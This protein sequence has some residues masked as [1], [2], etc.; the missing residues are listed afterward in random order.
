[1]PAT[2]TERTDP[3]AAL[4]TLTLDRHLPFQPGQFVTLTRKPEGDRHTRRAYSIA[5]APGEPLHFLFVEV[6][7]GTVSTGLRDLDPGD[8]VHLATRARGRFVPDR[9]PEG[10]GTLWMFA[11]G[12]GIAPYR[13][14]IR[15]GSIFSRVQQIVLV[16]GVR[17][18]DALVYADALA[19]HPQVT[20]IPLIS[21]ARPGPGQLPGRADVRLTDG[22]LERAAGE[23]VDAPTSHVML[24]GNPAMIT[25]VTRILD[26]RGL[27]RERVTT[28]RYW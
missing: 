21:R 14:M 2:I 4:F 17:H 6:Q 22:T 12:T 23:P 26:A 24:C 10:T 18:P 25:D 9:V 1:M 5:S 8:T 19:A 11:T 16:Y 27:P 15:D 20:L 13:S 3:T 7:G 28:E